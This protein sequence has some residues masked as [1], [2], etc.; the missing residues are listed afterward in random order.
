M[1][2]PDHEPPYVSNEGKLYHRGTG[3]NRF[4]LPPGDINFPFESVD[5]EKRRLQSSSGNF[6][7]IGWRL[8]VCVGSKTLS[9]EPVDIQPTTL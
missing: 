2:S 9:V 3:K 1:T 6:P 7:G 4:N 8:G 5:A